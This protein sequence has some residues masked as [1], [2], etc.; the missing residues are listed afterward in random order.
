[1][2][3]NTGTFEFLFGEDLDLLLAEMG[4]GPWPFGPAESFAADGSRILISGSGTF[5]IG[6]GPKAVTGGGTFQLLDA[7][8]EEIASGT[9]TITH[10]RGYV[11]YGGVEGF[12]QFRGGKLTLTIELD[13][14]GKGRLV[15][16]CLDG[17]PP[18][19]KMEGVLVDVGSMHFAAV[20]VPL[21][22]DEF[23]PTIFIRV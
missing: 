11:D 10:L 7:S 5:S 4:P 6:N 20:E 1:M 18:P 3:E 23:S 9:W 19:S 12:P 17:S 14:L 22:A 8:G 16:Y 15:I 2:S 21:T 13:G